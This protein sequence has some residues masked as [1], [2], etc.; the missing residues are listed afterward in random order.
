MAEVCYQCARSFGGPADLVE[1]VKKAHPARDSY[2]SLTLN[3]EAS[4]PGVVCALC[5]R[6]YLTPAAL[7]RHALGPYHRVARVAF[8]TPG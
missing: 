4:L 3:P 7:A 6:R 2:D 1:H 5:G 8:L